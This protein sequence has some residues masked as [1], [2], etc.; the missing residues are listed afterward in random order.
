MFCIYFFSEYGLGYILGH[1]FTYSSGHPGIVPYDC[2]AAA[3]AEFFFFPFLFVSS[4][5]FSSNLMSLALPVDLL[6]QFLHFPA[7]KLF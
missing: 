1:F 6:F 5:L 4:L 3:A 2:A 7:D